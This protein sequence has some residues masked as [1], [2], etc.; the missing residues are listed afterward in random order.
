MKRFTLLIVVILSLLLIVSSVSATP[1]DISTTDHQV[2]WSVVESC[3]GYGFGDFG[4]ESR[5]VFRLVKKI[6]HDQNGNAIKESEHLT[7]T[8][9]VYRVGL[10][11]N[12]VTGNFSDVQTFTYDADT[13]EETSVTFTGAPY[14]IH[15]PGHGVV[16]HI[17]GPLFINGDG[18]REEGRYFEDYVALCSFFAS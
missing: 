10:E 5:S 18:V 9:Y 6:F 1:P 3:Q 17:A 4:I 11:N 8:D 12:F 14:N 2:I 16:Y 13:G 15:L 7:G